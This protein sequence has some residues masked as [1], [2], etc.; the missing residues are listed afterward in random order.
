[1]AD[2]IHIVP[3]ENF[4]TFPHPEVA[5]EGAKL[6]VPTFLSVLY[7]AQLFHFS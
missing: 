1:M 6:K 7:L 2:Y 3:D 5:I 4:T